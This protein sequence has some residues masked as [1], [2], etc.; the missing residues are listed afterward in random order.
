MR[1][2]VYLI[3]D[4]FEMVSKLIDPTSTTCIRLWLTINVS[5][6]RCT[7]DYKYPYVDKK[8][9]DFSMEH[10]DERA[11]TSLWNVVV[12]HKIKTFLRGLAKHSILMKGVRNHRNVSLC[13]LLIMWC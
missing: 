6:N 13:F 4:S 9:E 1:S 11:W 7:K 12:P 5:A 2:I 8:I 3:N 10:S